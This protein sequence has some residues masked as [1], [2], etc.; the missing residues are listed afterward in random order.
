MT[1]VYEGMF[2]DVHAV[3]VRMELDGQPSLLST[4]LILSA[5]QFFNLLSVG[6]VLDASGTLRMPLSR[7]AFMI[8]LLSLVGLNYLY[9]RRLGVVA[10]GNASRSAKWTS[11]GVLYVVVSTVIFIGAALYMNSVYSH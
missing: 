10:G 2:R 5:M 8:G 9:A 4:V 3:T 6:M 11:P 7:A 1:G